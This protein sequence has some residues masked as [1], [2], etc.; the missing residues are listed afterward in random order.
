MAEARKAA[1][2]GRRSSDQ[3]V[4]TEVGA[5][6]VPCQSIMGET[7]MSLLI[8][9]QETPKWQNSARVAVLARSTR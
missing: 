7:F 3:I 5:M 1:I 8:S 6:A 2:P 9:T 4:V